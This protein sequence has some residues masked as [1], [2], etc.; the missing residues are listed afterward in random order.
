MIRSSL[1]LS[2]ESGWWFGT[3]YDFPYI[4][5]FIIPTDFHI[6]QMGRST[7]N[8][9]VYPYGIPEY[10][11]PTVSWTLEAVPRCERL[12]Q[13]DAWNRGQGIVGYGSMY[14]SWYYWLHDGYVLMEVSI[15]GGTSKS[16]MLI[17]LSIINHPFGGYLHFWN[18]PYIRIV[19]KKVVLE[20]NIIWLSGCN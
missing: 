19:P 6:F 3:F 18:P 17:G 8:Q 20:I 5:K 7:T 15:N 10:P 13:S 11:R 16:S 12:R 9:K 4:G 1:L 14:F 2:P